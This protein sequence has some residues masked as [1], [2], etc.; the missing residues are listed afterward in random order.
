VH[1]AHLAPSAATRENGRVAA[2][3]ITIT[4]DCGEQHRLDHD[5]SYT[6]SCGRTWSTSQVPAADYERIVAVDRRYRRLGW[7][8]FGLLALLI[9]G[10]LLT[11]PFMAVVLVPL[12]L[13]SWF[14]YGRPI[15]R[16]RHYRAISELTRTW[17]LRPQKSGS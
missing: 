8:L 17:K 11:R 15:V 5:E 3:K 13:L 2:P 9:L 14:I 7:A 1:T 16:R 10:V 6:C 4:C 12:V